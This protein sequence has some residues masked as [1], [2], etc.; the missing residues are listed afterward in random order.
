MRVRQQT[1]TK[2]NNDVSVE[3]AQCVTLAN[4]ANNVAN[5]VLSIAQDS[6]KLSQDAHQITEAVKANEHQL[7]ALDGQVVDMLNEI[8]HDT[9]IA[10]QLIATLGNE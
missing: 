6:K 7:R 1:E 5:I 4:P 2:L 10:K 3:R 9:A 8:V